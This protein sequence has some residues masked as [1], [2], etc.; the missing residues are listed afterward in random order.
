MLNLGLLWSSYHALCPSSVA[1]GPNLTLTPTAG[2]VCSRGRQS[3]RGAKFIHTYS[4]VRLTIH[5][6][7][8]RQ[9]IASYPFR[10][11]PPLP[12]L[13]QGAA[14]FSHPNQPVPH[15]DRQSTRECNTHGPRCVRPHKERGH[16]SPLSFLSRISFMRP[17][18]TRPLDSFITCLGAAPGKGRS[19]SETRIAMEQQGNGAMKCVRELR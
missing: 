4:S 15:N 10:P 5:A 1:A 11:P 17:G 2:A 14:S 9:A 13:R 7:L 18:F 12:L 3:S 19:G 6:A 16:H 8:R